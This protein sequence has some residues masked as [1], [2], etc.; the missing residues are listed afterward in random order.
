[1]PKMTENLRDA[2]I[3]ADFSNLESSQVEYFRNNF[4]HFAP[5]AWW[6]A[7]SVEP[8]RTRLVKRS[9]GSLSEEPLVS[10]K[11]WQETQALV[12]AWWRQQVKDDIFSLTIML[13]SVFDPGPGSAFS[14]RV[15]E[16]AVRQQYPDGLAEG[17]TVEI[18]GH[19]ITNRSNL[20]EGYIPLQSAMVYLFE[21][22]WRARFCPVCGKRFVAGEPKTK[23]CSSTCSE[24]D[25]RRQKR[26]WF[27]THGAAWRRKRKSKKGAK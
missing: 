16:W 14:R 10:R 19:K 11:Q 21:N 7:E 20:R 25:R 1:M 13:N 24:N 9:D 22:S 5:Q 4:P 17:V 26:E 6:D 15:V 3:L 12:R 23:F 27:Q 18:P 2:Q 8:Q